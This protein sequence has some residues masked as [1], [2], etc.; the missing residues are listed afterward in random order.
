M[1]RSRATRAR[2]PP[3]NVTVMVGDKVIVAGQDA[4]VD[5]EKFVGCTWADQ[6][7]NQT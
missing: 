1:A 7:T 4:I 5:G 2:Y 3:D 6:K